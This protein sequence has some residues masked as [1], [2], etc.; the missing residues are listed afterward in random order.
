MVWQILWTAVTNWFRHRSPRQGAALAYYSVFSIGPLLLI[1]TVVAGLFFGNDAVRA[2]ISAQF[3]SLL[4]EGGG[5]AIDGLLESAANFGEG[6]FAFLVGIALLLLAAVGIVAQ[7]KDAMNTIWEVKEPDSAGVAWYVRTYAVSLAGVLVL[8][9]LL[10]T[11]LVLSAAV[12]GLSSWGGEG[13]ETSVLWQIL[14][15]VVSLAVLTVLFAMVFK[16][17]PDANVTWWDALRGGI[18]TAVLFEVGKVAI[19][20]YVAWAALES[21]YG[22]AGSIVVLLIWVYYSAQIVLFG[23]EIAHALAQKSDPVG[24]RSERVT[25]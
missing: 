20:W 3:T 13:A 21:A 11:S 6:A 19:A 4:G 1:V 15:S 8:G 14:Q 9:L 25:A 5:S 12:A 16:W 22:A 7:L 24:D 18:I 2:A 17:L 23:A 10:A